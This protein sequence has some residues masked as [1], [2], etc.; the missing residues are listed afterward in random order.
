MLRLDFLNPEK[1]LDRLSRFLETDRDLGSTDPRVHVVGI[2][3]ED[4]IKT[5]ERF[6]HSSSPQEN[7]PLQMKSVDQIRIHF[8]ATIQNSE[9]RLEIVRVN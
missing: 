4:S 9:R 8:Q 7:G 6:G 1:I 2:D 3:F 5:G